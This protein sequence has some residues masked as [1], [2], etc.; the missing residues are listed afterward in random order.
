MHSHRHVPIDLAQPFTLPTLLGIF[1]MVVAVV[2]TVGR[3][4]IRHQM[5]GNQPG[6]QSS[7]AKSV[8][9]SR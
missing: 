4:A 9:T 6:N 1:F 3:V 8:S 7:S 2:V 5:A